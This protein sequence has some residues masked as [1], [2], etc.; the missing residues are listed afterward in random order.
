LFPSRISPDVEASTQLNCPLWNGTLLAVRVS[1]T[2]CGDPSQ[3]PGALG[4]GEQA[5]D[6]G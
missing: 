3:I 6:G 2:V 4:E 1:V 5:L